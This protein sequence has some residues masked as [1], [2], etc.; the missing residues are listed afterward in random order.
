MADSTIATATVMFTDLRSSTELRTRVGE[1]AAEVLRAAHDVTLNDAVR[2]NGGRV[3]KHLG[4]GVMAVFAS[5]ASAVA[6]GVAI[7]QASDL[8]NRS[9]DTD[10]L[11]VRVGISAGDVTMEGDDCF[12][13]PV[14]EA[15][16]LEAS[17]E[18][19]TIRCAALVM[20]LTRGRGGHVFRSLGDL[21]LKGLAEPVT[22]CEVAWEP[23]EVAA[24]AVDVGLPPVLAAGGLPFS[25]RD[26][27]YGALVE[28]W[29]Q[30]ASGAFATVLLAG[31]PGVGKTRLARELAEWVREGDGLVLAGRCDE[32]VA[33]PFQAFATA[34]EWFVRHVPSDQAPTRLG[35]FPG[36]LVRIV[37]HLGELVAGLPEP[38]R[39]EPDTERFR[40]LQ[41]VE[42][43]LSVG[44]SDLPRL[45]VLDDLHWADT[46]TLL[47][48]R[49]LITGQPSGLMVLCTYRDTDVD[50]THPL[51]AM[52]ADLRRLDG[53][54]RI[55]LTGLGTGGVR[56]LL[57]RTSGHDLG[58]DGLRFADM[59]QRETSGNPFFLS[60]VL[61]HLT[62]TGALYER[63]GRWVSDLRPEHLGI[64]EGVREVVGRRLIRLGGDVEQ[65]LR[66]AAVIGY[67]FDVEL[68]ADVV[69]RNVDEVLDALDT[70]ISA[71]LVIEVGVDRLRFAHALVRETL[72]AE[73]S[74]SRRARQHRKVAEAIEARHVQDSDAVVT[75]L[76]T[77]WAEASAGGDPT[78]AIE[79]AIRAG[80][81]AVERGAYENGA[82][83][84]ANALEMIGDAG[85]PVDIRRRTLV[86]LAEAQSHSGSTSDG[87]ANALRAAREA[88]AA[89]DP[90]TATAALSI[91]VRAAL[92]EGQDADP[93]KIGLLRN[94]LAMP[95]LSVLQRALL[96]GELSVELIMERDIPGRRA[97]L[98][99]RDHL[100][101]QLPIVDQA[102]L[103]ASPGQASFASMKLDTMQRRLSVLLE[104]PTHG[105]TPTAQRR[106][107][108][109]MAFHAIQVGKRSV[110]DAALAELQQF[111]TERP[112]LMDAMYDG[113]ANMVVFQ[114][115]GRLDLAAEWADRIVEAM[116]ASDPAA[117]PVYRTVMTLAIHRENGELARLGRLADVTATMG[118]PAAP[119]RAIA[120]FIR[121]H[122]G[123]TE[124]IFAA[125]DEIDGE[126]FAD[127]AGYP[128]ALVYWSEIV[129]AIGN[130]PQRRRF[131]ELATSLSGLNLAVGGNYLGPADRLSA[132]L[133]GALGD[134]ELADEMFS[135]AV[136]QQVQMASP[137]WI[138]RTRLDWA[139][140]LLARGDMA[141]AGECI[142]GAESAIGD[143]GLPDARSR[144]ASI[145]GRIE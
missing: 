23:L 39:D 106:R 81:L 80:D 21:T 101:T 16:R 111:S 115:D 78:R 27:S 44:G 22:A 68:L 124:P 113:A 57:V 131:L 33:V 121:L 10:R 140:S 35:E 20:H 2:A 90:D 117:A 4:D 18:P 47:L 25:G 89:G 75:E 135:R 38:L 132:L 67:E 30:C 129:A 126:D 45:L 32:G 123:D 122:A 98:E 6:A 125:L 95:G 31:E 65:V 43:W 58:D 41:A 82:R 37:P 1:E 134:H 133:H 144:I 72:H 63:D 8:A 114:I 83:W 104:A 91:S 55:A 34:L 29:K 52:L 59:M 28:V 109:A 76:A 66:T 108:W 60:E 103:I 24:T 102:C 130:E 110:L 79:L 128:I 127:D 139:E 62:E 54:E 86:K 93:E 12:G 87:R 13:L 48:L 105:L 77:H 119:T 107:Q 99:E 61:R 40:L 53:V 11:Q 5:A 136:E 85:E 96:F 97:A 112:T 9:A 42:S 88:I 118:H 145:T 70:A 120:A 15:Q 84:F 49:Q 94:A 137:P 141:S 138:A 100:L 51:A 74:S 73:L 26:D 143:L 17:A 3:V 69:G 56:E 14:I 116:K 36:D 142:A 46:A 7:Q 92:N 71:S 64:P 19:G 50:R